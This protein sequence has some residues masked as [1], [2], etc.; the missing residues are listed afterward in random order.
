[1]GDSIVECRTKANINVG[2]KSFER[3]EQ[4]KYLKTALT[5]QNSIQ[6][7]IKSKCKSENARYHLVQN[8]LSSSLISK[9][10]KIKLYR[11]L[12]LP[13][14]LYSCKTWCLH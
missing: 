3:V 8:L 13:V 7:E 6:E 12:I 14:F 10:M 5:Y 4:F 1:M 11:T 2:N 9:N